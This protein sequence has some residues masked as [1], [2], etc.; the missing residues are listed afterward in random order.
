MDLPEIGVA[1]INFFKNSSPSRED[2]ENLIHGAAE[3]VDI[4]A[5]ALLTTQFIHNRGGGLFSTCGA[6]ILS[7]LA[8]RVAITYFSERPPLDAKAIKELALSGAQEA[9]LAAVSFQVALLARA[10]TTARAAFI[11]TYVLC[12]ILGGAASEY[13]SNHQLIPALQEGAFTRI[14]LGALEWTMISLVNLKICN[15]AKTESEGAMAFVCMTFTASIVEVVSTYL[16]QNLPL[17]KSAIDPLVKRGLKGVML[18]TMNLSV[19]LHAP[20]STGIGMALGED[21]A[22]SHIYVLVSLVTGAM[23]AYFSHHKPLTDADH[24]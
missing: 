4:A 8:G 17:N 23:L 2:F 7:S 3:G 6:C 18:H 10:T 14:I 13:F 24:L 1:L 15:Q 9:V 22:S 5:I 12:S 16:F 21:D 11:S 20:S 19:A